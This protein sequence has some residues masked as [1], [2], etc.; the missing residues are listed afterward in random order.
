V[1]FSLKYLGTY[2]LATEATGVFGASGSDTN[3]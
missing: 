3:D 2:A 1:N